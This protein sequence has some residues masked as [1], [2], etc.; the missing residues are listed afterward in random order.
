MPTSPLPTGPLRTRAE[1]DSI[2]GP[3]RHVYGPRWGFRIAVYLGLAPVYFLALLVLMLGVFCT[4]ALL[5]VIPV[6][7]GGIASMIFPTIFLMFVTGVGFNLLWRRYRLLGSRL[8]LGEG[9]LAEWTPYG[10]DIVTADDLGTDWVWY[11][12]GPD[13]DGIPYTLYLALRHLPTGRRVY[14]SSFYQGAAGVAQLLREKL[15][16]KSQTTR[17]ADL[18][19]WRPRPEGEIHN[20]NMRT[21]PAA[22]G[23]GAIRDPESPPG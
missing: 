12:P 19:H 18:S 20:T 3:V 16:S 13:N 7:R 14:I 1:I 2:I 8:I 11:R 9:G 4:L 23:P 17:W 10:T 6:D 21:D 22:K 15:A 5:R